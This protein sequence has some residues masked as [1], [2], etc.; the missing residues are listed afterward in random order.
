MDMIPFE[1]K[2]VVIG[3]NHHNTLGVVRSLGEKGVSVYLIIYDNQGKHCYVSKSKYV[4]RSWI[5]KKR[6]E[7]VIKIL[8]EE[9]I[10]CYLKPILIPTTDFA[11]TTI[12][13][14]LNELKESFICPTSGY[15]EGE[16]TSLMNK[17]TMSQLA[18]E[19]GLNTPKSRFFNIKNDKNIADVISFP[20]V[21]KPLK[22]VD[23][24]RE[25]I[26]VCNTINDLK[27]WISENKLMYENI[28]IQDYIKKDYELGL[29]GFVALNSGKIVAP[30][31]IKKIREFPKN[32]GSSSFGHV[33][34]E[35]KNQLDMGAINNF[36]TKT[37]YRGIF[38]ME[39]LVSNNKV[40]FIEINFRNGGNSY[41]LTKAGANLIYLWCLE[42][43]GEA[44]IEDGDFYTRD[45][46]FMM[47]TRDIRHVFNRDIT[48]MLWIKDLFKTK[49]FLLFNLND[50]RP[51][52]SKLFK[53]N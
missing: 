45:I 30:A 31:V 36:L 18:C 12:D 9:F 39:F 35:L 24:K 34:K 6:S 28:L 3:S 22:S 47:D 44:Q 4:K 19:A 1:N 13:C 48:L 50:I 10:N 21:V 37:N 27:K 16:I 51:F 7:D 38:D 8:K 23:G 53:F 32:S 26:T 29:L 33:S 15:I 49:G 42:A 17:L 11:E 25:D 40:Y 46:H 41:S 52:F 5:I 14:H 43:S 2:V 20:C